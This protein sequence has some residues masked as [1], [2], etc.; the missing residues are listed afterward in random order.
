MRKKVMS[1]DEQIAKLTEVERM[2][3]E[4]AASDD[5]VRRVGAVTLYAGLVDFYTIQLA[6]LIEQVLLKSQLAAAEKPKFIPSTD[7][8]FYDKRI[9][10]RKIV[11]DLKKNILPFKTGS[12]DSA[13]DAQQANILAKTLI[14]KTEKFLNYRNEII[15]HIGNPKMAFLKLN[16]LCDKAILA[17]EDFLP[18]HTAFFEVIRPYTFSEKELLYFYGIHEH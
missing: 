2:A 14:E 16:T 9:D 10:T 15:H 5:I 13:V 18:T 4:A 11:N 17:Y 8:Y 6:R 12:A 3:K 1:T 7:S